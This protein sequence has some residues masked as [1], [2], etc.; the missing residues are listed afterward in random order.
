M[1][2][3][4]PGLVHTPVTPFSHDG[5]IALEVYG[6]LLDFHVANGAQSLALPMH[7]GESVSLTDGERRALLEFAVARLG[8]RIPVLAHVSESGSA[9]AAELARHAEKAGAAAVIATTPYYWTPPATMLIEH[10]VAI[11]AATE[12]P[13]FIYNAPEE[14]QGAR[15]TADLC[16]ELVAKLPNFAGVVDLSLDWQFMIELMTDAPRV[17]PGFQLISG[18]ELMVSPAAIGATGMFAPLA[19]IAPRMVRELYD[20][21]RAEKLFEARPLQE[22]LAALR[23]SIKLGGVAALKAAMRVMGRDCGE[24]RAPVLAL[25]AVSLQRLVSEL[26][27]IALLHSEPR[28]W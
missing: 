18:T 26:E 20:L 6:K 5:G 25:E 2:V 16:R 22:Q 4:T 11:G 12:L 9:I 19:A 7:I 28:G 27:A 8:D 14:M 15:I 17:R 10:F 24:P 21:C 1:P 23:Q 3:L 13:F